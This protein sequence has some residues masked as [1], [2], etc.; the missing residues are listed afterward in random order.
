MAKA[1]LDSEAPKEITAADTCRVLQRLFPERV[2]KENFL[3][4][5]KREGLVQPRGKLM[6]RHR[7]PCYTFDDVMAL[8]TAMDIA[9]R[10]VEVRSFTKGLRRIQ[11]GSRKVTECRS[12][13]LVMSYDPG[14]IAEKVDGLWKRHARSPGDARVRVPREAAKTRKGA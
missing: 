8:A 6:S 14:S 10:G 4:F 9:N 11:K 3:N 5:Y 7:Q 2:I 1:E 12:G 13:P